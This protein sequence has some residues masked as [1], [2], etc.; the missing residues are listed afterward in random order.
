MVLED[1]DTKAMQK[2]WYGTKGTQETKFAFRGQGYSYDPN[3]LLATPDTQICGMDK[4]GDNLREKREQEKET[5]IAR[6][7]RHADIKYGKC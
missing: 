7:Q 1:S 5:D 3:L 4:S 6:S 2:S